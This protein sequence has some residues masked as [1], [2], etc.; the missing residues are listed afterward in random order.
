METDR[1][2]LFMDESGNHGLT[3]INPESSVFL[4]CGIL[5]H[6][7]DYQVFRQKL[8]DIKLHFWKT[9]EVIFHS[10]DIR[11]CD[12]E[13]AILLDYDVK[14]AFYAMLNQ[15]VSEAKYTIIVSAIR[16]DEYIKRFG[17]LSNDV[18]ELSLS[19]IIER[20]IF[21]LDEI[22]QPIKKLDIILEQRG[23]KEDTKLKEHFQRITARGT[24]YVSAGRINSYEMTINFRSKIKNVNGLQLAD[25]IAYPCATFVKEPKRPNPS[26]DVFSDKIYT[27]NGRKYGFKV[28]P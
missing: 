27:R 26:F 2:Y 19:F 23:K 15:C 20:A 8:N 25:L 18:Y 16:K 7:D 4:L 5:F 1:Y 14:S 9:T 21:K 12:K 3:Q 10:R 24:G 11:K 13:F 17:K 28:Y 6:A 22:L